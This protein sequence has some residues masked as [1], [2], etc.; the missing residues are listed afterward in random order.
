LANGVG[1]H[2]IEAIAYRQDGQQ[3]D[4]TLITIEV[5]PQATP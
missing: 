1:I 2:V 5:L 4:P 3:S